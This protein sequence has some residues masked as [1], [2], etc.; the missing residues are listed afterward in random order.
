[1]PSK[2]LQSVEKIE[3]LLLPRDVETTAYPVLIM[4][5]GLPGSGKSHLSQRLA[6]QLSAVVIESDHVRK[7]LFPEPT[8]SAQ[9]STIVHRT[10]QR[11]MRRLLSKGVRVIFDATNLVEFQREVL[12]SLAE[13]SGAALLIVR[14]VAPE[15]VIRERLEQRKDSTQSASDADWRIYRRMSKR[16]QRIDRTHLCIDTSHDIDDAVR[17]IIRTVR[18]CTKT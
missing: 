12:Y 10:C 8:Y 7:A 9:E 6:Q 11:T 15:Q 2:L 4:M 13:R 1:V 3:T 5:S 14:T 17:K 18:R 16:E